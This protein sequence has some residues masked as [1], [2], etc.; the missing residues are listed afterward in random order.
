MRDCGSEE[1]PE[2]P[3]GSLSEL[4]RSGPGSG[5]ELA[6]S[7]GD[8]AAGGGGGDEA[9]SSGDEAVAGGKGT[10]LSG[11]VPLGGAGSSLLLVDGRP[12]G[13]TGPSEPAAGRFG[14]HV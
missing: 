11:V 14:N 9:A 4:L 3:L 7:G 13:S 5:G 2:S 10:S 12:D 6:A 8:E 1:L